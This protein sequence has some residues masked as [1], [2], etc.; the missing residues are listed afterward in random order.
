MLHTPLG[1][2]IFGSPSI[3]DMVVTTVALV[4]NNALK[5]VNKCTAV[6]EAALRNLRISSTTPHQDSSIR[7]QI[8][9]STS[10]VVGFFSI[11]R[12]KWI[13][14]ADYYKLCMNTYLFVMATKN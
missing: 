5:I 2:T 10:I 3:Q 14:H 1:E 13:S 4:L 8:E 9:L 7:Q 12:F 6:A 11:G